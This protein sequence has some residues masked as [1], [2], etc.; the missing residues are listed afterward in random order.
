MTPEK[1]KKAFIQVSLKKRDDAPGYNEDRQAVWKRLSTLAFNDEESVIQP[2]E[3]NFVRSGDARTD[4]LMT[5]QNVFRNDLWAITSLINSMAEVHSAY[6]LLVEEPVVEAPVGKELAN[7]RIKDAVLSFDVEDEPDKL[8]KVSE[9]VKKIIDDMEQNVENYHGIMSLIPYKRDKANS[10][11]E[12]PVAPGQVR[13][14][15][16]FNGD[17][18]REALD[19]LQSTEFK[20]DE[21]FP[22]IAN[23][24]ISIVE[25]VSKE[26]S[27]PELSHD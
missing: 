5:F 27:K 13:L 22:Q 26:K 20:A 2:E 14:Y 8:R 6:T 7:A 21:E 17:F 10:G 12:K 3:V 23:S 15:L 1:L 24:K 19:R 4:I 16:H 25:F 11:Q 9:R 18:L